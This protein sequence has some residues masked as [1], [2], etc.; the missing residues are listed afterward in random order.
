MLLSKYS[1]THEL[2]FA[3]LHA[4][5]PAVFYISVAGTSTGLKPSTA[6]SAT[7]DSAGFLE[8]AALC[9]RHHIGDRWGYGWRDDWGAG[10]EFSFR[11]WP[12]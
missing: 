5:K 3:G 11:D 12:T 7:T 2:T 10:Y 8:P 6:G 4:L 9:A 1:W